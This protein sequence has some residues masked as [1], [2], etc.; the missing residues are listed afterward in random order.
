[1]KFNLNL[2]RIQSL[3]AAFI[4]VVTFLPQGTAAKNTDHWAHAPA[5]NNKRCK[6]K[7]SKV[8][9][10]HQWWSG[11]TK[12]FYTKSVN[13]DNLYPEGTED[14]ADRGWLDGEMR[15]EYW[16]NQDYFLIDR[17]EYGYKISGWVLATVFDSGS[18][19]TDPSLLAICPSTKNNFRSIESCGVGE[20]IYA[21]M[22]PKSKEEAGWHDDPNAYIECGTQ[23]NTDTSTSSGTSSGTGCNNA[24]LSANGNQEQSGGV[25]ETGCG[26]NDPPVTV[27]VHAG[28]PPDWATAA[29]GSGGEYFEESTNDE[30]NGIE[31]WMMGAAIGAL[32]MIV[33]IAAAVALWKWTTRKS[34]AKEAETE[35]A[36]EVKASN[37]VHV[38]D[39][40][41]EEVTGKEVEAETGKVEVVAV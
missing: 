34:T 36:K 1:M 28:N 26:G 30:G 25:G 40:S 7:D 2:S 27:Q 5:A 8:G 22:C 31:T 38:V 32:A 3:L 13:L 21:N 33:I 14:C 20:W 12:G 19:R 6:L 9:A 35:M 10:G 39:E 15:L 4:S 23:L 16:N 29:R 24:Q 18:W 37:V 11:T 17:E 41:V